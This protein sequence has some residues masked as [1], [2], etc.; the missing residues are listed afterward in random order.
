MKPLKSILEIKQST[1]RNG[2]ENKFKF[3]HEAI[4]PL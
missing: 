3:S 2:G 1:T 4:Q